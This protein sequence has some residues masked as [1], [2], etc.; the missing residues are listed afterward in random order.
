MFE[1]HS[2]ERDLN[3]FQPSI[4]W[5]TSGTSHARSPLGSASIASAAAL[6]ASTVLG[7]WFE[8]LAPGVLLAAG[9]P[10]RV[11]AMAW[12]NPAPRTVWA[13]DYPWGDGPDD[14]T[15]ALEALQNWGTVESGEFWADSLEQLSGHRP[16][17]DAIR[18]WAKRE[19]NVC[20]RGRRGDVA[21]LVAVGHPHSAADRSDPNTAD[22]RRRRRGARRGRKDVASLMPNA[23]I[24]VFPAHGW[25]ASDADIDAVNLPR[26]DAVARFIGLQPKPVVP[27]TVAT[28]LCSPM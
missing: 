13:R 15:R 22:G 20:T 9:D 1:I 3:S 21:D 7:G 26:L 6:H 14:V 24:E 5:R 2:H 17:K 28:I 8:G 23:R 10:S 27:D 18:W 4:S 25:M 11:P 12:W 19:R 16:S